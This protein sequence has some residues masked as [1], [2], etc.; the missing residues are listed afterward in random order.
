[1]SYQNV[2]I[3][4]CVVSLVFGV[5]LLSA[6]GELLGIL[7][8][9]LGPGGA[10]TARE[11]A[12]AL[13]GNATLTWFARAAAPSDARRAIIL[14]LFVYDAIG[15]AASLFTVLSGVLNSLGWSIVVI[16][17]FFTLAFGNLLRV[18]PAA[19]ATS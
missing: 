19:P 8:T 3:T 17:L 13:L 7:G 16:Y 18:S 9:T 15:F 2:M 5:V 10:F 12:A 6:P 1:M 11:Y 14:A 4:K